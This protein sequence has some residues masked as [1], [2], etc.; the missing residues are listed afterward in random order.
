MDR[1]EALATLRDAEPEL[2]RLGVRHAAIF[3]PVARGEAGPASDVDLMIEIDPDA[4]T[5]I[6]E[7]VDLKERIASLLP[8]PVDV[9]DRFALKP[10]IRAQAQQDAIYAF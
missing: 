4:A 2:H 8:R 6:Y 9:V 3:G 7:Y 5:G 1:D 10:T